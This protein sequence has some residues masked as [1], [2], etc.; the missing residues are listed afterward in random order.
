MISTLGCKGFFH[1]WHAGYV[2]LT[3]LLD[4]ADRDGSSHATMRAEAI[5]MLV[6]NGMEPSRAPTCLD[7]VDKQD[8]NSAE[9]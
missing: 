4:S 5:Q 2:L 3:R 7:L 6:N 8:F 9:E 1:A